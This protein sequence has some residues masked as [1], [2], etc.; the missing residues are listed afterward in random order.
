MCADSD[1]LNQYGSTYLINNK[2]ELAQDVLAIMEQVKMQLELQLKVDLKKLIQHHH[3]ECSPQ[4]TTM[5][6]I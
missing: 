4:P 2:K 3:L 1:N 6:K 5:Q